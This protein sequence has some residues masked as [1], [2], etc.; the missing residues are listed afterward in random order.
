MTNETHSPK[1]ITIKTKDGDKPYLGAHEAITWFR[2]DHPM[3]SSRIV[4][5]ILDAEKSLIRCEIYID[6]VLVSAADVKGDGTKSLEKLETNAVRRALAFAGYGTVSALAHEDDMEDSGSMAKAAMISSQLDPED[7][8]DALAPGSG[9]KRIGGKKKE[10]PAEGYKLAEVVKGEC[11]SFTYENETD[12][13]KDGKVRMQ[14]RL[15]SG[16]KRNQTVAVCVFSREPFVAAGYIDAKEDWRG[17]D[18]LIFRPGSLP[19]VELLPNPSNYFD[20]QMLLPKE[21]VPF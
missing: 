14:V 21:D 12:K 10:R 3:P 6:D 18:G 1:I 4:P 11:L 17:G 8:R 5:M 7:S 15:L 13:P 2:K 19:S 20:L 16:P 9:K